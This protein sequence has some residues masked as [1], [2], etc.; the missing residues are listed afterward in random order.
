MQ[1]FDPTTYNYFKKLPG[2]DTL[3]VILS[4][5]PILVEGPSDELIVNYCYLKKYGKTPLEVGRD[6][7]SVKGLSFK[8]F[9]EIADR[10]DLKLT[11]I[12]D[13]DGD[14]GALEEKYKE[15]KN[16]KNIKISYDYDIDYPTLE[17]QIVKINKIETLNRVFKK[18]F[19]TKEDAILWMTSGGN[20][21]ECA[22]K[23]LESDGNILIPKYISDVI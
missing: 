6:V 3:R 14:I 7:I 20:K 10:L 12:T 18:E 1:C 8:R 21:T 11:V 23:I 5:N 22:L 19:K 16:S 15:F 17:P 9:L 2:H 13:N 4:A